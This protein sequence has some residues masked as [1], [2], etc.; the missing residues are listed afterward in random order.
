MRRERRE[1]LA[2]KAGVMT[3]ASHGFSRAAAP[4]WGFSRDMMW[5]SGLSEWGERKRA[6]APTD[7]PSANM[8]ECAGKPWPQHTST[9]RLSTSCHQML[10]E[11]MVFFQ[12]KIQCISGNFH[13]QTKTCENMSTKNVIYLRNSPLSVTNTGDRKSVV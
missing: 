3:G 5:S 9:G 11:H 13:F 1:P 7:E 12:S 2:D 8:Q 6:S 4:V 10:Q